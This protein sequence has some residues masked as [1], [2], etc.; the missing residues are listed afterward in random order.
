MALI[1]GFINGLLPLLH[2]ANE[3]RKWLRGA[4][5]SMGKLA[6]YPRRYGL[7][8]PSSSLSFIVPSS[9]RALHPFP[10]LPAS[11]PTSHR[12][13]TR[14]LHPTRP[15]I[16]TRLPRLHRHS[17]PLRLAF[18]WSAQYPRRLLLQ[19]RGEMSEKKQLWGFTNSSFSSRSLERTTPLLCL[20][21]FSFFPCFRPRSSHLSAPSLRFSQV[22]LIRNLFLSF[23]QLMGM[24]T[25][26]TLMS[27]LTVCRRYHKAR[28]S[29]WRGTGAW[30]RRS[31]GRWKQ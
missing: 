8:C 6:S 23:S 2:A 9:C 24:H 3:T 17:D 12:T 16:Y 25:S 26:S 13:Q 4:R 22:K 15:R 10:F 1:W 21:S 19:I 18:P 20:L 11:F 29:G 14:L 7:S 30:R 5:N 27:T 31:L 28:C